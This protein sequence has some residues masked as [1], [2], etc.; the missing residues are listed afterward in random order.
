M[1]PASALSGLGAKSSRISDAYLWCI[2]LQ[3]AL[4]YA[5]AGYSKLAGPDLHSGAAPSGIPRTGAYGREAAFDYTTRHLKATRALFYTV[6]AGECTFPLLLFI[7]S[8]TMG[9][10]RFFWPFTAKY[11]ALLYYA[12]Q[13][14]V[15]A[16]IREI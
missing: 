4:A 16:D 11:P 13:R 5:V 12:H 15:K 1:Q 10:G 6:I 9:L 2:S 14:P 8:G 7:N 3:S